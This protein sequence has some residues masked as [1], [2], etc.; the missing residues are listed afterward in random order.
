MP[1]NINP[2]NQTITQ[3]NVQT[4]AANNLLNSVAPGV[5]GTILTSNG[6]SAQP[7]F[8]IPTGIAS[9]NVQTITTSG[10]Y[11]PTANC[12]FAYVQICGGGAGGGGAATTTGNDR[13]VGR[14]GSGA[15]YSAKTIY[16]PSSESVTIGAGGA[17]GAAGA[18][19]GADGGT[20]SFGAILTATGGTGGIGGP[21][22]TSPDV[23]LNPGTYPTG[24]GS[25]GDFNAYGEFGGTPII[26]GGATGGSLSGAGGS[27]FFGS[28]GRAVVS[29]IAPTSSDGFPGVTYGSGGS[30]AA[31]AGNTQKAGG[32]GA[33]GVC[34]VTEFIK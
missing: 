20:S 19:D 9:I 4:G 18:N 3:Y 8:Q 15:G 21:V 32:A 29:F 1:T 26:L 27:S 12:L 28:G 11:T 5:A 16:N 7:S 13:S 24:I 22:I 10:T 23:S 25:G 14:G 6:V 30:G 17:G 33:D 31:T 2:S 34:I